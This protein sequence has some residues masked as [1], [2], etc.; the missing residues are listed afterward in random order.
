[1]LAYTY[2]EHGKFE[3][4]DKPK[5]VLLHD[6]DTIVRN[7]WAVLAAACAFISGVIFFQTVWTLLLHRHRAFRPKP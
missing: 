4:Q 2:I 6:R 1:M 5:P 3:L 7:H